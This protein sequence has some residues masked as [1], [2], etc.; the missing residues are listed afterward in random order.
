[1]GLW[2]LTAHHISQ[3]FGVRI[4]KRLHGK[5]HSTLEQIEHGHHIF[6]AYCKNSFVKQY[7]KFRTFLRNEVC[8]NNLRDFHLKKGLDHLAAVRTDK[9]DVPEKFPAKK[10]AA[11]QFRLNEVFFSQRR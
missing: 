1:V 8:S 3:I 2:R 7:E 9:W 11:E 4:T 10:V 6:R 5:L